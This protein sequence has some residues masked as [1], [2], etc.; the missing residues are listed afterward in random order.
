M[1]RIIFL[2]FAVFVFNLNSEE[3]RIAAESEPQ[4]TVAGC[5]N[6]MSGD[7]FQVD[8]D[9]LVEGPMPLQYTRYYDAGDPADEKT[10]DNHF[11]Y[12][13]GV[14]YP[15]RLKYTR[16]NEK[17]PDY[18]GMTIDQRYR[19]HQRN[20]GALELMNSCG[21]I[22]DNYCPNRLVVAAESPKSYLINMIKKEISAKS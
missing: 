5:V 20:E 8:Q 16:S 6:I 14:G 17:R 22:R 18:S 9:F 15:L 21:I 1:K 12:G 10:Y 3:V 11:G 7:F 4:L 13:V 2:F 19:F